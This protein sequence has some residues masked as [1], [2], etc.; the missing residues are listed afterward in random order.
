MTKPKIPLRAVPREEL[1]ISGNRLIEDA[2]GICIAEVYTDQ[3][4]EDIVRAVNGYCKL[5]PLVR[6]LVS[7]L[8]ELGFDEDDPVSGADTVD[9]LC[10][11]FE[12]LQE[13]L[14]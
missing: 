12:R 7:D 4:A 13:A 8:I 10:T 11:H 2:D 3:A 1:T 6:Q 9:V 5:Q 14:K